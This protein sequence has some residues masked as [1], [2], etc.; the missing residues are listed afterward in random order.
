VYR[1]LFVRIYNSA[2]I[3]LANKENKGTQPNLTAERVIFII[4]MFLAAA[5][6]S[7]E[8]DFH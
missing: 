4:E 2:A 5:S 7:W 3:S 8:P 1:I 6:G